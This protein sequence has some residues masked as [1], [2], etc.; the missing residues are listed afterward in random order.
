M[1]LPVSV[2]IPCY[3]Q[4]Q[5][6]AKAIESALDQS[7]DITVVYDAGEKGD[8]GYFHRNVTSFSVGDTYRAGVCFARNMGIESAKNDF[9]LCLDADDRLY[10]DGLQ[11]LFDAWKPGTWCY[12]DGYTEIDENEMVIRE[13]Q[14]PPPQ[15]L[16]RKNLCFSTFLFHRDDWM[17]AGGFDPDFEP[18]EEDYAFQCALVNAGVKPVRVANC[19]TYRR[20]IHTNSRT[21]KAMKYW[22]V[23]MQMCK[24]KFPGAFVV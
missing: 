14:N 19:W 23:T 5:W 4:E 22:Q 2:V 12:G 16:Y 17:K 9:I 13:M 18:L 11:K 7:D 6:V 20:M 1:T 21:A 24:D 15:M 10:Q 3:K 8:W